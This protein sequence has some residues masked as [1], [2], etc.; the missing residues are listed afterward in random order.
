MVSV[1]IAIF[2]KLIRQLFNSHYVVGATCGRP[3]EVRLNSICQCLERC[4]MY[5]QS[6]IGTGY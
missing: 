3:Q 1:Q 4:D 2:I 6:V 5:D